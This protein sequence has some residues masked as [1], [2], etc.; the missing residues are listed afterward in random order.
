MT[1]LALPIALPLTAAALSLMLYRSPRL[2]RLLGVTVLATTLV[3]SITLLVRVESDGILTTQLGGFP[4]PLGITLV[5]DLLSGVLLVTA[6][7]VVLVVLVYALG[8]PELDTSWEFFHPVFLV[9]A[10][11]VFASLLTGDLF[12]LFVSFEVMLTASYVLLTVRGSRAQLRAGPTYI[13]IS[14][15]AS[16]LFITTIALTYAAA[17]TVNLADLAGRLDDV[18]EGLREALG[19][20]LLLVLGVKAAL[21]PLAFWVPAAY[22]AAP[23]AVTALFAGLL[24]KTAVYAIIR[25]QTLLFPRDGESSALLLVLAATTMLA[26]VLAA[27]AQTDLKRLLSF[28]LVSQIGYIA[29][30][31]ALFT[32]AG[33]A[34]AV[35]FLVHQMV[36]KTALFLVAGL[37]EL[38]SGTARLDRLGG[39]ARS[40]ALLAALFLV[41]ALS[42]AGLPPLSGFVGKLGL[43]QA[44][45]AAGAFV[46]AG[47]SLLVSLLSL[48]LVAKVWEAAFWGPRRTTAD[49]ADS[50]P[51]RAYRRPSAPTVGAT[52]VLAVL[53]LALG[54]AGQPVYGL[55]ERAA[56]ALLEREPYVEA[57]LRR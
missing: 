14:L 31:L 22:P 35:Y 11:G 50:R 6:A 8:D 3:L 41:P 40:D 33:V 46:V 7:L 42:L 12:N 55:A 18:D 27:L 48:L 23:T 20:L 28:E 38:G 34:A 24:T 5:A 44:G 39:L 57:V 4:A 56:A 15:L 13:T 45:L 32:A 17:G 51:V 47:V 21:V 37:V 19:V 52:A 9:L 16:T 36:V 43:V 49:P 26:G 54:V 1:V 25:T 2:Q 53:T 10:A 29:F 30:G